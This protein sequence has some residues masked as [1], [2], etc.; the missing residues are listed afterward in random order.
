MRRALVVEDHA[1]TRQWWAEALPGVFEGT[2]VHGAVTLQ[3]G[4]QLLARQRY[5]MAVVDIN[6]PDGSGLELV[7]EL[8][9]RYPDTF[10]VVCTIFDDDHHIFSALRRGA[11]GYLVKDQ[12]RERQLAQLREILH[13]QPP[14][15]PGVARRILRFVAGEGGRD[16]PSPGQGQEE[17]IHL[18]ERERQILQLIAKGYSRPEVAEL[19]G[20]S[21]NT[22]STYTKTVY[23]KLNVTRRAEAVMEA[24]RLGLVSP[25][26]G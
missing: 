1:E 15:S 19:L 16:L 5:W 21:L 13:G 9:Q 18:T 17:E 10:C 8:A 23:Q 4:R 2:E 3:E 14:L 25:E 6:L 22:V 11:H 20:L 24:M 7:S 12:P 26:G